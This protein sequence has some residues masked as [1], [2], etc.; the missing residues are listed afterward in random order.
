[1]VVEASRYRL[2]A[3][4]RASLHDLVRALLLDGR[5]DGVPLLAVQDVFSARARS[6]FERMWASVGQPIP[7]VAEAAR[8]VITAILYDVHERRIAARDEV[9]LLTELRDSLADAWIDD[10]V[11][12]DDGL[13]DQLARLVAAAQSRAPTANRRDE[14][15]PGG[16]AAEP[17][18][19]SADSDLGGL[20][21]DWVAAYPG[22]VADIV[23]TRCG[24]PVDRDCREL[25]AERIAGEDRLIERHRDELF[26]DDARA[27]AQPTA[28]QS[29][30]LGPAVQVAPDVFVTEITRRSAWPETQMV[31]DVFWAAFP[32]RHFVV[33]HGIWPPAQVRRPTPPYNDVLRFNVAEWLHTRAP[34]LLHERHGPIVYYFG[35]TRY[36]QHPPALGQPPT[37]VLVARQ[38]DDQIKRGWA[39]EESPMVK[40]CVHGTVLPRGRTR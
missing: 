40:R 2:G 39:S 6:K 30:P 15:P 4:D 11:A 36:D 9:R 28:M 16:T 7:S 21:R 33:L 35:S 31:L 26:G 22:L 24:I 29:T 8:I 27:D 19:G 37:E 23:A 10:D 1:M 25:A 12:R 34:R 17:P 3:Y 13:A 32:D 38:E 5:D 20:A 18:A 14:A